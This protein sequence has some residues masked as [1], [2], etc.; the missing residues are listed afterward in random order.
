MKFE[1]DQVTTRNG[2]GGKSTNYDGVVLSKDDPIF[3]VLGEI[4]ELSSWLGRIAQSPKVNVSD[5][6]VLRDIQLLLQWSGSLVATDPKMNPLGDVSSDIYKKLNKITSD[7]VTNLEMEMRILLDRGVKIDINFVLPGKTERSADIDISRTVCRRAERS[8]VK[9]M[10]NNPMRF[11]L[12]QVS[13]LLNRLSD[14]LF[15]FARYAEQS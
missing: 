8:I 9:F 7:H 11:D 3:D 4:D 13:I 10:K 6:K 15:I 2:D 1:F 14:Y 5:Y 12:K